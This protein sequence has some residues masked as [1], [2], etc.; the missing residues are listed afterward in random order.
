MHTRLDI[1]KARSKSASAPILNPFQSRPFAPPTQL[2]EVSP[3]QQAT[4]DSKVQQEKTTDFG[5]NFANVSVTPR[6]TSPPPFLQRKLRTYAASLLVGCVATH[7]TPVL[8]S[9]DNIR[10]SVVQRTL[11]TDSLIQRAEDKSSPKSVSPLAKKIANG[12]AYF[13]HV[14]TQN[15][16]PEIKNIGEFEQLVNDVLTNATESKALSG[17]RHA[18]WST[19]HRTIVITDPSNSDGGTAFRP[20]RGKA[21]YDSQR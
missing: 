15:E 11:Q 19:K 13:K 8:A 2:D 17:G 9:N 20:S 12:H 1:Q 5:Y 10:S 18:Y 7:L 3:Q 16:Y 14:V 6:D 21:Y 4:L